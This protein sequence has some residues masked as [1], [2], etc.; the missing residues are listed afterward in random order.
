MIAN[1]HEPNL[2]LGK[3]GIIGV[4]VISV[5]ESIKLFHKSL[6]GESNTLSTCWHDDFCCYDIVL[7]TWSLLEIVSWALSMHWCGWVCLLVVLVRYK[8]NSELDSKASFGYVAHPKLHRTGW[9]A[10]MYSFMHTPLARSYHCKNHKGRYF[11]VLVL[12]LL[13]G[14]EMLNSNSQ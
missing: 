3:P 6:L 11:F 1:L 5:L 10:D 8:E 4:G 12:S 9:T 7:F 2:G 14:E 13:L